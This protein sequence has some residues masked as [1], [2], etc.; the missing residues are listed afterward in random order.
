VRR[1]IGKESIQLYCNG[2]SART[3]EFKAARTGFAQEMIF[4]ANR[5][6][7]VVGLAALVVFPA[8]SQNLSDL[9]HAVAITTY[10]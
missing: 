1:E 7:R 8:H 10:L 4:M 6:L 3:L 2:L 5:L 9:D